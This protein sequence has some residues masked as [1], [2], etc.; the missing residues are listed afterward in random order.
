MC[1]ISARCG[2]TESGAVT[3]HYLKE[4]S[5]FYFSN[6]QTLNTKVHTEIDVH[7]GL[8][9]LLLLTILYVFNTTV[10]VQTANIN[11]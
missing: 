3:H 1:P 2:D 11:M 4:N 10:P 8:E 6:I 7:F 9:T 5:N